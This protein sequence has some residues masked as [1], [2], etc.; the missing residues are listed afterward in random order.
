MKTMKIRRIMFLMLAALSLA[1][2][3]SEPEWAD[4][5]AHEKTEQLRK[6]YFPFIVGTWHIESIKDKGRFFECLT[7]NED[8]TMSGVRKWQSREL[9]TIDGNEQYTDWQDEEDDNGT[10]AGTWKLYWSREKE[11][12]PGANRLELTA[13]FDED[14]GWDS[15]VA[16]S[17]IAHFINADETTLCIVGGIVHN[18]EG[19][20]TIYTRG[21]AVPSF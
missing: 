13:D 7:F 20:S 4:P 16:Y 3:S 18:G 2:C 11:G 17:V 5:E 8:G 12:A 10:F 19:G 14:H 15:P 21:Y 6:Q 9:V 1:S